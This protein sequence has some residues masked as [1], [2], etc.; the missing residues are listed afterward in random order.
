[1]SLHPAERYVSFRAAKETAMRIPSAMASRPHYMICPFCES[2]GLVSL[3]PDFARCGSCGLPLLGSMLE[4]LRDI[5]GLPDAPGRPC[6]RVRPSL[7]CASCPTGVFHCPACRSEVLPIKAR[8]RRRTKKGSPMV[9]YMSLEEQVDADFSR[10]RRRAFLRRISARLRKESHLQ[11]S[12]LLRG[13][14]RESSARWAESAADGR[15]CA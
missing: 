8:S 2:G 13:G 9:S 12:A 11:P 6:L 1:M 14:P 5:V 3:G 7:R 4:T 10:A 15:R